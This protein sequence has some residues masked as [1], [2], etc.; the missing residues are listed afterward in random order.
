MYEILPQL[1][2]FKNISIIVNNA[3]TD[4]LEPYA[5]VKVSKIIDLVSINCFILAALNYKFI[6]IFEKRT[7][8][9]G[10][11]CAIINV[12]SVAGTFNLIVG[13]LPLPL[14]NVYSA[15]KAY[16]GQLT[17]NLSKEYPHINWLVLKPSEVTTAMA[18]FK[19]DIFSVST[20][21]CV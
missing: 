3:G 16:V 5:G 12:G 2:Q 4:V 14:H 17:N 11:K 13:E 10:N 8:D 9:T 21:Q 20:K 18:Y 6:P 1:D 19:D 7:K 15:A